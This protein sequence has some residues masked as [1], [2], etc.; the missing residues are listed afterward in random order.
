M[1]TELGKPDR[2]LIKRTIT[3]EYGSPL[4]AYPDMTPEEAKEY[5]ESLSE[6]DIIELLDMANATKNSPSAKFEVKVTLL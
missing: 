4:T 5:E 6:G 3:L 2:I 1:T